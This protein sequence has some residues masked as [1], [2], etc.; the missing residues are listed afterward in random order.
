MFTVGVSK[1]ISERK[2]VYKKIAAHYGESVNRFRCG[3]NVTPTADGCLAPFP[4]LPLSMAKRNSTV[5]K[6]IARELKKYGR[7]TGEFHPDTAEE[8][9]RPQLKTVIQ[10]ILGEITSGNRDPELV[11]ILRKQIQKAKAGDTKAAAFL[12]DRAYGLPTQTVENVNPPVT[13]LQIQ[14]VNPTAK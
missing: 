9:E 11:T 10:R 14:I 2:I 13:A 1:L 6:R 7:F 8:K 12:L 4:F 3:G 5:N